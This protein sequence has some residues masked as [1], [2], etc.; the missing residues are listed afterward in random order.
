MNIKSILRENT[1]RCIHLDLID[2]DV[3]SDTNPAECDANEEKVLFQKKSVLF[4][5]LQK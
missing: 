3:T 1:L 4:Q 5:W 2:D